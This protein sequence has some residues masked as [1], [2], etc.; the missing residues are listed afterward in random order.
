[1]QFTTSAKHSLISGGTALL[2]VPVLAHSGH[3]EN[4]EQKETKSTNPS[5]NQTDSNSSEKSQTD[6]QS[7]PNTSSTKDQSSSPNQSQ[8]STSNINNQTTTQAV[9]QQGTTETQIVTISNIPA[10]GETILGLIVATPFLLYALRQR[11]HQ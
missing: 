8:N 3:F 1:M 10:V 5:G 7:P 6:H 2:S 4:K 9:E 11:I